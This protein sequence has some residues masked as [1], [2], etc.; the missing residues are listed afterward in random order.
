MDNNHV[1]LGIENELNSFLDAWGDELLCDRMV[2]P[3]EPYTCQVVNKNKDEKN[4]QTNV[5]HAYMTEQQYSDFIKQKTQAINKE[6]K[7]LN[8][9]FWV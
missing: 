4:K 6:L 5:N 1:V 3:G 2:R 7:P 8:I 9:V